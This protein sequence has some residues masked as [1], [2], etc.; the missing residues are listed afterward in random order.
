MVD[1][2][3]AARKD[4]GLAPLS[5]NLELARTARLK[6]QDMV[7]K[8]Y[9]SHDSPTYGSPFDMMSEFGIQFTAAGENIA[10]NQTVTAAHQALMNSQGHRANILSK[11]YTQIGI[12]IVNG[13]QC[14]KMFTQQFI[15]P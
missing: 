3:N 5:V 15:R 1:L 11:E 10:C 4:A 12:G 14:G 8:N 6:S 13:G 9:F 7:D 2:V